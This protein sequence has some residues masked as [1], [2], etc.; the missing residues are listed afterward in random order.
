MAWPEGVKVI[1]WDPAQL[2]HLFGPNAVAAPPAVTSS[3]YVRHFTGATSPDEEIRLSIGDCDLATR[4]RTLCAIVRVPEAPG[5][6]YGIFSIMEKEAFLPYG[7]QLEINSEGKLQVS[8]SPST[9]I[10]ESAIFTFDNNWKFIAA[11]YPLEGKPTFYVYDFTTEEWAES[12]STTENATFKAAPEGVVVFG[13]A[14]DWQLEGDMA[15]VGV[16]PSAKSKAQLEA[17]VAVAELIDWDNTAPAGLWFLSQG[18]ITT[19]VEDRT[20]G[21]ADEVSRVGTE[22]ITGPPPIPYGV[23]AETVIEKEVI[24][25]GAAPPSTHQLIPRGM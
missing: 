7:G 19:P 21:D 10:S 13:R 6:G 2:R 14:T 4:A 9:D 11:V 16:Y 1:S 12:Q 23:A 20:T 22:V 25:E 24:K 8:G 18:M 17:L 3:P 5:E 15:A